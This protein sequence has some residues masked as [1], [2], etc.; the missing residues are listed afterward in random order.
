MLAIPVRRS[1]RILG[2]L[3]V[4]NR[5]PRQFT[6][7]EVDDLQTVAMLL[8]EMLPMKRRHRWLAG[9]RRRDS[10]ADRSPGPR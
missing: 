1:G 5:T 6:D 10:A 8:A 7:E 3:A 2:I 4:Q 9:R